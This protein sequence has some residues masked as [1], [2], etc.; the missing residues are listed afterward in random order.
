MQPRSNL[1]TRVTL[2][3]RLQAAP[4]DPAVW[5]EFVDWYGRNIHAWCKAWGLQESDAQDVTQEVF[6]TLSRK[7]HAFCYDRN[8]SFRAWLKTLTRRAWRIYTARQ[9]RAGVAVGDEVT[10]ARLT[11]VAAREDLTQRLQEA[12]DQEL[13]TEAS[14]LV[15][16][17]VE[18]RTWEAFNLLAV[19]GCSGTEAAERLNM[20]VATVFV[21]RSKV[22]RML[23]EELARLEL[24]P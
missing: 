7:M 2:L 6:L 24:S 14:N 5:A 17:R 19:Q 1:Q 20:K 9:L 8:K 16:L 22:Q 12:F 21:A 23:R 11:G 10:L 13:L 15:R 4:D 3:G 18:P